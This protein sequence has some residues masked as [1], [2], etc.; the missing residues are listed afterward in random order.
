M[1]KGMITMS[2]IQIRTRKDEVMAGAKHREQEQKMDKGVHM[3]KRGR[4]ERKETNDQE[5]KPMKEVCK[6]SQYNM[7]A[8]HTF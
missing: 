5:L 3:R 6:H 1:R 7:H 8:F 4:K 2:Y